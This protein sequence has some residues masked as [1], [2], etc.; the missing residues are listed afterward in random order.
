MA[1]GNIH[2]LVYAE[3]VHAAFSS[4]LQLRS[5]PSL[6]PMQLGFM[7][8]VVSCRCADRPRQRYG[9]NFPFG[10]HIAAQA[11]LFDPQLAHKRRLSSKRVKIEAPARNRRVVSSDIVIHA[12]ITTTWNVLSDY[13]RLSEFIPN[14]AL[15]RL[16]P[17]PS[18]GGIR[19]EQCGAQKILGFEFRASVTLDMFEI[20]KDSSEARAIDFRLVES[21]DFKDFRGTWRMHARTDDTT[22]LYYSVDIVPKGLVPVKAIEWRIGE[23]VPQNMTAVKLECERRRRAAKIAE[24]HEA[25]KATQQ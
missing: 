17:H 24:R 10:G 21:R 25:L 8:A 7:E 18:P 13:S 11:R 2:S 14:L 1:S 15:S 22:T 16:R 5:A 3:R 6:S 23:D 19:L 20:D 12:P 4:P 9:P